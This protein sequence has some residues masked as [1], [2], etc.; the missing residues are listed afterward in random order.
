[1]VAGKQLKD[2]WG[3]KWGIG[4]N[5]KGRKWFSHF[6]F[7]P[8]ILSFYIFPQQP[9]FPLMDYEMLRWYT[10]IN[11]SVPYINRK[12]HSLPFPFLLFP[13]LLFPFSFYLFPFP[14]FLFPFSFPLIPFPFFLLFPHCLIFHFFPRHQSPPSH[15]ILQNIYPWAGRSRF[16]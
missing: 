12:N 15:S 6:L 1:M 2:C 14:F 11:K 10:I 8:R 9:F 4:E 16:Q 13:F 5:E 7:I 3:K